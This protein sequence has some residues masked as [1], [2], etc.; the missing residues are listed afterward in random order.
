MTKINKIEVT[1][2]GGFCHVDISREGDIIIMGTLNN[3]WEKIS[4]T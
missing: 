1:I 2:C 4:A 3:V